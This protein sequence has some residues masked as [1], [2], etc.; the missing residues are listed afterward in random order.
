M[1]R[2]TIVM[3][4]I[5]TAVLVFAQNS[6]A[7][8]KEMSGTVELQTAGSTVWTPAKLND[9]IRESTIIST[10]FK[11]SAT[12]AV[13]NSTLI[14]Q[15]LT[16]MSLETLMN[17][18]QT[19]TVGLNLNTGRMK[20]DV[21]PPSGGKTSTSVKSPSATASV[22]GTTFDLD[23]VS[24]QVSE[25]SVAFQPNSSNSALASRPVIVSAGQESRIDPASGGAINPLVAAAT[26]LQLP[27]L[28][29]QGSR[30]RVRVLPQAPESPQTGTIDGIINI[31]P[32]SK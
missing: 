8:I 6:R 31:V 7:Y 27:A 17:R 11:S 23:T 25:G 3:L 5:N 30:S 24:I 26:S 15:A 19:E 28:A 32:S 22:R 21:K 14:V 2:I 12:I 10:G 20:V 18:D 29:G 16:R 4:L 9:P 1:K 13:G